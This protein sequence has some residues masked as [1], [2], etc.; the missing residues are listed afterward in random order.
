MIW[1]GPPMVLRIDNGP[2]FI[3]DADALQESRGDEQTSRGRKSRHQAGQP[4]ITT[5]RRQSFSRSVNRKGDLR[6]QERGE[7]DLVGLLHPLS[8]TRI[9]AQIV[10]DRRRDHVDDG[11]VDPDERHTQRD[12]DEAE[13]ATGVAGERDINLPLENRSMIDQDF[14]PTRRANPG[15]LASYSA[16]NLDRF[17]TML[18]TVQ[19]VM[20]AIHRLVDDTD[21]PPPQAP[22]HR[23][24]YAAV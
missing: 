22:H 1:G 4:K 2:E 10:D 17:T 8:L 23:P 9:D 11:G 16:A 20:Q 3:S 21:V 18:A 13:P 19:K 6:G 7:G 14:R 5:R 12:S 15:A 24:P